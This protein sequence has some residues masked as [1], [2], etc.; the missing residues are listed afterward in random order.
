MKS[1][2][3]TTCLMTLAAISIGF[4]GAYFLENCFRRSA[5]AEFENTLHTVAAIVVS[6]RWQ[7]PWESDPAWALWETRLGLAILPIRFSPDQPTDELVHESKGVEWAFESS[8]KRLLSANVKLSDYLLAPPASIDVTGD[9]SLSNMILR[10][11]R[12]VDDGGVQRV[13]WI[14]WAV[15]CSL[16]AAFVC[17]AIAVKY[18]SDRQL[19][20]LLE[21]WL[22]A[23]RGGADRAS[24]L[25]RIESESELE[26][27]L[28]ILSESLNR[29]IAD[30][31]GENE[32][33]ELV[34]RNLQEGILA[35]D[36]KSHVLLTNPALGRLLSLPQETQLDR[37]LLE[38][39]RVPLVNEVVERIL[40]Q[41]VST[42][43]TLELSN[44]Q[45]SLRIL[46][47]PLPLPLP[48]RSS[49]AAPGHADGKSRFGALLTIRDETAL[50]RIE[51]IRRDF[52]ANASHELKTPLSAIRAY[53]ETLQLGALD[54]RPMAERFVGNIIEQADRINGLVQGML[55]LSRVESGTALRIEPFDVCEAIEPCIAAAIA[56]A[57][58]KHINVTSQ[59]PSQELVIRSDRDGFQTIASNL[60]SNAVRY[61]HDGGKVSVWLGAIDGKCLLR[62]TDT[63]IGILPEDLERIFERF[64]R[65]EKDRST[66][67]GGTGLGLAIVKHLAHSLGG[68]VQATS[69]PGRGSSFEVWLPI[70]RA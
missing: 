17:L 24:L 55:Q 57:R 15:L 37:L 33:S 5:E 19:V 65:A 53:A 68:S 67:S 42:E 51:S 12:E 41:R 9:V 50:R 30:L 4:T 40:K 45:R 23:I 28:G 3:I 34:L 27:A 69:E 16:T 60:L 54:D 59:L 46:G 26:P 58:S 32:R 64:Y 52:V 2:L 48:Q 14:S 22:S 29:I 18:R 10:I 56:V 44:P 25:P 8:G 11:T 61:T 43:V 36:E 70:A 21:P 47:L 7:E 31:H 6:K 62:V 39:V 63:G 35:I 1:L 13:W 66:D 49:I 38:L 20:G